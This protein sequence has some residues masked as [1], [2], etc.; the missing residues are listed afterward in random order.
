MAENRTTAQTLAALRVD[1]KT[2]D[3]WTDFLEIQ[4]MTA[5]ASA[6]MIRDSVT[7][8]ITGEQF[9][10]FGHAQAHGLMTAWLAGLEIRLD[11]TARIARVPESAE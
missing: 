10:D 5:I 2:R 4:L 1:F 8:P 6:S 3:A 9:T 11:G 7:A